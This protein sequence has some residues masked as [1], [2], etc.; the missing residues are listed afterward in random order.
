VAHD[1]TRTGA[2]RVLLDLLRELKRRRPVPLMVRLES[3]GPLA[4]ELLALDDGMTRSR[5]SAMLVNSALAA[6][7]VDRPAD[8]PAVLYVHE[9]R[10]ALELLPAPVL[11]AIP[12][13]DR[14]L[15]VSTA[16][17]ADVVE[18]GVGPDRVR[19]VPPLV[20]APAMPDRAAVSAAR[21]VIG[22]APG[23]A[24]VLGCGEGGWHKGADLFVALA[25][26]LAVSSRARFGWVGLRPLPFADVLDHDIGALGLGDRFTWLG[27]VA[28][29]QP[30][31][32]AAD[33]VVLT[34]RFDPQPLVPVESALLGTPAVGFAVGGMNDL[35]RSAAALSVAY[36]DVG[37]L[38][39]AVTRVVTSNNLSTGL[40]LRGR[41]H[42]RAHQSPQVVL[43]K[44]IQALGDLLPPARLRQGGPSWA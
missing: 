27:E 6:A 20:V 13:Y 36:P 15:C 16:V 29:P 17:A 9:D 1:A 38:A 39:E 35:A 18:L 41:R 10:H 24:I 11:E 21:R 14:V 12:T 43:P 37:A 19:V 5:P 2:P 30:Y 22:A 28:R 32:A 26:H 31:L 34:S 4:D 8:V 40:V 42:W 33:V 23:D 44:F 25:Q 7:V 3:S